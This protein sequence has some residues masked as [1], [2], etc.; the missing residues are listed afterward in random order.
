MPSA[1]SSPT[2]NILASTNDAMESSSFASE[3]ACSLAGSAGRTISYT[4]TARVVHVPLIELRPDIS[5]F[6]NVTTRSVRKCNSRF[7]Y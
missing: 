4:Q 1:I 7:S 6:M 3:I 2:N 5:N